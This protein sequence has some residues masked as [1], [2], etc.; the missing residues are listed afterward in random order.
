MADYS[1]FGKLVL[2][3]LIGWRSCLSLI[4]F[5]AIRNFAIGFA[6]FGHNSKVSKKSKQTFNPVFSFI[7]L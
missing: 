1:C 3:T 4:S 2:A 5:F 7:V 6:Q